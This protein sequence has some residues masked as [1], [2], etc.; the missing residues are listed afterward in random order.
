MTGE[1]GTSDELDEL[2]D[3][4]NE[5][6]EGEDSRIF[7]KEVVAEFRNPANV[8]RMDDPDGEGVADGLCKDTMDI[9]VKVARGRIE[10]CTFW[11]DGC[12][13]TI[14]CGSVLT[15]LVT[16]MSIEDAAQ[17]VPETLES[18]LNGLPDD[19]RHCA[20]LT[21]IALRN[22]LRNYEERRSHAGATR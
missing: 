13:V 8:G 22:A 19:H 1:K 5:I 20:S 4:I 11:T 18:R 16:G 9:F 21:V 14:A 7:S 3:T 15:K 12:G 10:R 6:M 2:V 17:L